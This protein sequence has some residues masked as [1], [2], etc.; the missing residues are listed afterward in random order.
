MIK[1]YCDECKRE[2]SLPGTSGR[3]VVTAKVY[4][5]V[6][7]S[8]HSVEGEFCSGKCLVAHLTSWNY[9]YYEGYK[10]GE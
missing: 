3:L 2:I 7:G 8:H 1:R 4:T 6:G 9:F 5:N 10:D